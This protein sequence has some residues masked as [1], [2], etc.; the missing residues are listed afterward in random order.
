[1]ITGFGNLSDDEKES[2]LTYIG[3]EDPEKYI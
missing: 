2:F 3:V 1:M